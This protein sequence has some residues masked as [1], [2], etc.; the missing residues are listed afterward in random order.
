MFHYRTQYRDAPYPRVFRNYSINGDYDW[1]YSRKSY[2]EKYM[3]KYLLVD[4]AD[5]DDWIMRRDASKDSP[6]MVILLK[7]KEGADQAAIKKLVQEFLD[8]QIS[9]FK[10]YQPEKVYMMENARVQEKGR[11][12]ALIVSPDPEKS[13][14][15]LG[16]GWK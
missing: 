8:E 13:S 15:A 4:A 5:F 9:L 2:G 12:I 3:E 6:E 1:K 14:A 16:D 7:V 10:G 11:L